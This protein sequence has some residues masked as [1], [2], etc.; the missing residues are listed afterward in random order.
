MDLKYK[1]FEGKTVLITGITSFVGLAMTE[2][3][4]SFTKIKIIGCSRRDFANLENKHEVL[5]NDR[6][7]YHKVDFTIESEVKSFFHLLSTNL[8]TIDYAFNIIG[9]PYKK[10]FTE[11]SLS[12]F[13]KVIKSNLYTIF[14]SM[15]YEVLNMR[16]GKKGSIV[17]LSSVSGFKLNSKGISAYAAGKF[18][19]NAITR[20]VALEEADNNIRVNAISPGVMISH[21]RS[22]LSEGELKSKY[23]NMHPLG[24]IAYDEDIINLVIFL[25]SED[26][27]YITGSIIPIDG[28]IS[29][30]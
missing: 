18:G 7:T 26:S 14:L 2:F 29:A 8:V 5:R 16:K 23:S 24:R 1:E 9:L 11:M 27:S 17:N 15:K 10:K 21:S 22:A 25:F 28:G 13:D 19:V 4:I 6:I 12:E 3:L 20:S 30:K